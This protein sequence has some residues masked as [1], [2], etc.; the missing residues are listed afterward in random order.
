MANGQFSKVLDND[1]IVLTDEF[2]DALNLLENTGNHIF[3]TGNAG[4]GKSTLISLWRKS[5]TKKVAL[6]SPTGIAAMNIGGQT[7]HS[8]F[9]FPLTYIDPSAIHR[10]RKLEAIYRSIESIIVDEISMVRADMLDGMD[11]ALRINRSNQEPFGGVQMIFVGDLHQLPPVVADDQSRE[12]IKANYNSEY[13]FDAKVLKENY[14]QRQ[15]LSFSKQDLKMVKLSKIFRQADMDF[16][17]ILNEIRNGDIS[18][19]KLDLLNTRYKD[20]E[21]TE[22]FENNLKII[23]STNNRKVNSINEFK[24]RSIEN[25]EYEYDAEISGEYGKAFPTDSSLKLRIGA[26]I[27]MLKNDTERRWVN[28]SLG[29]IEA[30]SKDS[31]TVNINGEIYEVEKAPWRKIE[32]RVNYENNRLEEYELGTFTQ[33]PLKLAWAITIHKSQGQTFEK[34]VIDLD[35]GTFAHGQLYVAL[36]R[37]KTLEGIDLLQKV[38]RSDIKSD[39]RIRNWLS[40]FD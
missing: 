23:L 16:I 33:F 13:F 25:D 40:T 24:L 31:V 29:T 26:Q 19:E 32:Y 3:V 10:S 34:A 7:I 22:Y 8:F 30:L 20:I 18:D 28:G 37:C 21:F 2:V 14:A 27:M 11:K 35:R 38:Q 9:D 36:S 1:D 39:T 4:T 15:L 17:D 6:V 12:Y 5:T